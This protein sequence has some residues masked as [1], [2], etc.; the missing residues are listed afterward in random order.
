MERETTAQAL[1]SL[2]IGLDVFEETKTTWFGHMESV[3][4]RFKVDPGTS[5]TNKMHA[6]A[7]AMAYKEAGVDDD[8]KSTRI[9]L[10]FITNNPSQMRQEY[11][12]WKGSG[13]VETNEEADKLISE[14]GA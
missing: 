5:W 7:T 13:D 11:A 14:L 9:C 10:G 2:G 6:L 4:S 3:G 12:A 8:G 1:K